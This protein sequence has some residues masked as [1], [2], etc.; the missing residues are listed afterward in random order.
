MIHAAGIMSITSFWGVD[1][2]PPPRY[3][4]KDMFDQMIDKEISPVRKA[5]LA[6][7]PAVVESYGIKLHNLE[8]DSDDFRECV[9]EIIGKAWMI[10]GAFVIREQEMLGIAMG[11]EDDDNDDND[12]NDEEPDRK[13]D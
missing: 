8:P 12:E 10:G 13:T 11:D 9:G 2:S 3:L 4:L 6:A 7:L 5:A 1:Q